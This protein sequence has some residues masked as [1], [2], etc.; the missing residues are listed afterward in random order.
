MEFPIVRGPFLGVLMIRAA[1]F[2]GS[3]GG[4][5]NKPQTLNRDFNE[6]GISNLE[7]EDPVSSQMIVSGFR[8]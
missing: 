1:V 3:T 8:I 7:N 4:D 2:R 5:F 6:L